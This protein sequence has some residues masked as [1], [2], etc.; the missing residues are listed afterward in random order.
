M[1]KL[2]FV[3]F[4]LFC[5][6]SNAQNT[7]YNNNELE[8]YLED[9]GEHNSNPTG[10][11]DSIPKETISYFGKGYIYYDAIKLS[12]AT[13]DAEIK[14]I[15]SSYGIEETDVFNNLFL[16]K[17]FK[18]ERAFSGLQAS[19]SLF[20][21]IGN[22]N[23]TYFATGVAR[24]LAERSKDEIYEAF[25]IRMKKKLNEHEEFGKI[26]PQTVHIL[27]HI[28]NFGY[29]TMLPILKDAFETDMRSLP[30]NLSVIK[31]FDFLDGFFQQEEGKWLSLA[32]TTLQETFITPNPATLLQTVTH[33]DDFKNLKISLK[34]NSSKKN[35]Y[36][37]LSM[38]E[39]GSEIAQSLLSADGN[40]VWITSKQMD[41]LLKE[42]VFNIYLGILLAKEQ[43][44][45]QQKDTLFFYK[46]AGDKIYFAELL[47]N[48]YNAPNQYK[49]LLSLIKNVYAVF[50]KGNVSVEKIQ[51]A[52][53]NFTQA[54]PLAL[55]DYYHTI[56]Q[57]I[58]P[59][60]QG[61]GKLGSILP[62]NTDKFTKYI[63]PVV[64]I[65]Y[66]V[67]AQKYTSAIFNT[68]LLM[69]NLKFDSPFINKLLQF[70]NDYGPLIGSIA[71]AQSSEEVKKAIEGSA[72]PVGSSAMKRNSAWSIMLNAYVG[73]YYGGGNQKTAGNFQS[74]GLYAPIG[75][76]FSKGF[77][78]GGALS[79][80]VN[81]I[82][83]GSLVNIYLSEGDRVV[84]PDNYKVRLIDIF[85]PGAQLS[86]LI[87]QTPLSIFVGT[88]F[89]P[90]LFMF[91][92]NSYKGGVRFQAGVAI[93]I[94]MYKMALWKK[95]EK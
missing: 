88:N 73:G 81:V 72:L 69:K 28:E 53:Q 27:N 38:M 82:E 48:C 84:L 16:K 61:M 52:A 4:L 75:L 87:P 86:Y 80:T 49:E 41:S 89:I 45:N 47:N 25:F 35:D 22:T 1:K 54:D 63:T 77:G 78:K 8:K 65:V 74:Y 91:Q 20:T 32:L 34:Q 68:T 24:F 64:D 70:F 7:E 60:S 19:S 46:D 13:S 43:I 2:L 62:A 39:F 31:E 67:S 23:V 76:S 9:G 92:E 26:L 57:I 58:S 17:L 66:N 14:Q 55:Y 10:N 90:Q 12:Q 11:N 30:Q 5:F 93:D 6:F 50:N 94:P 36:N 3:F 83:L 33:S 44:R 40:R 51:F 37:L 71:T 15:L 29:A 18:D 21:A 42:D 95:R 56:T 59:I 85:S 79:F